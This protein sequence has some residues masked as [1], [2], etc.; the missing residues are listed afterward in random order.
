MTAGS[1][2]QSA[3]RLEF[4]GGDRRRLSGEARFTLLISPRFDDAAGPTAQPRGF[5]WTG[6]HLGSGIRAQ[7]HRA[8][9]H[10][11]L[12]PFDRIGRKPGGNRA[13]VVVSAAERLTRLA[14]RPIR[15]VV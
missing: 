13:K 11:D 10:L 7:R 9:S 3:A 1:A 4:T 8:G 6:E 12:G 5:S 15:K 2:A 14:Q